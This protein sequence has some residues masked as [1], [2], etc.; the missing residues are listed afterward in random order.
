MQWKRFFSTFGCPCPADESN[1]TGLHIVVGDGRRCSVLQQE[2]QVAVVEV[3]A[4]DDD[5]AS[6]PHKYCA[7]LQLKGGV[8]ASFLC[9]YIHDAGLFKQKVRVVT[10]DSRG[11]MS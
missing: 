1:E 6:L 9:G 10:A 2:H 8:A 7:V 11:V 5:T 4:L 3:V